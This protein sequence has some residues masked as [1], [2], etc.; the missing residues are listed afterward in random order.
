MS[1]D[2]KQIVID[3]SVADKES[4][5]KILSEFARDEKVS[6]FK[7]GDTSTANMKK[8]NESCIRYREEVHK[9]AERTKRLA[10]EEKRRKKELSRL[11]E[12]E[13]ELVKKLSD[14]EK[15]INFRVINDNR[16]NWL[17]L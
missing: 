16:A 9:L 2:C 17:D 15:E 8:M 6:V 3:D 11:R 4:I 12:E 5:Y 14:M 1:G 10:K 13:K 7:V